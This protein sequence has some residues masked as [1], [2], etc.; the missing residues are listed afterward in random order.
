MA[1]RD[2]AESVDDRVDNPIERLEVASEMRNLYWLRQVETSRTQPE[3]AML[4][5]ARHEAEGL[6]EIFRRRT[7]GVP[8]FVFG[9]LAVPL[10][11]T[12]VRLADGFA[13][14]TW[15][16]ALLV[17]LAG[18]LIG[19]SISWIALRGAAMASRRIRLT[20]T[21]PLERL[22]AT[23]GSCRHPP[24]DQSRTF[25][26]VAIVVTLGVWIVLPTLVGIALATH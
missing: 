16:V 2:S 12:I 7:I 5:R 23:L 3:H 24:K 21:D 17:G 14:A 8:S 6:R 9:G 20:V 1:T 13:F 11:A 10:L 25:A 26:T 18:A 22:W 15:W 4:A 19:V